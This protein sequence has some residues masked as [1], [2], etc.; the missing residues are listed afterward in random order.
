[1]GQISD[2]RQILQ[3]YWSQFLMEHISADVAEVAELPA[4]VPGGGGAFPPP[5]ASPEPEEEPA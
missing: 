2:C 4:T 5:Q 1:M 3:G